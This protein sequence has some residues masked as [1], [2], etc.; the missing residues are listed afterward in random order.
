MSIYVETIERV[1]RKAWGGMGK[2]GNTLGET[3]A[4]RAQLVAVA[5]S[6]VLHN[7]RRGLAMVG[8]CSAELLK[9]KD[10]QKELMF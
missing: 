9:K 3:E 4:E 7:P 2:R 5:W 1:R 6:G 8:I 10:E